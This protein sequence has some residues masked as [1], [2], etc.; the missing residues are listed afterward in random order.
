MFLG[1]EG[2][3]FNPVEH[4]YDRYSAWVS[5]WGVHGEAFVKGWNDAMPGQIFDITQHVIM[6]W[7]AAAI[8]I[9]GFSYATF[10]RN[11]RVPKGLRNFLE[12]IV[13]YFRNEVVRPSIK[14][15]HAHH[16]GD[17]GH[18]EGHGH[19]H[20]ELPEYWLADKFVPFFVC[21]FVFLALL[22]LMGLIPGS[23]TPTSAIFITISMALITLSVYA[24]GAVYMSIRQEGD[25]VA[26]IK[27]WFVNLVPYKFSWKP[28]DLAVWVLLFMI[29]FAGF[30]FIK[31]F[32]LAVRLFANMTAGHCSLL[33]F[34]FINLLVPHDAEAWRIATGIPTVFMGVA[35]YALEIFVAILQAYIFTY[36]SAIFLGLYLVP[37]H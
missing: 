27:G 7:I 33:S 22:N 24:V 1:S 11:T 5:M 6:M 4:L 8:M 31:P 28:M 3:A 35:L 10:A 25:V 30:I 37:E 36:L 34:L 17:H 16:H 19:E 18:G 9:V 2:G 29:E 20:K 12:P 14:N 32:A 26:G 13:L 15:P 23:T 21:M